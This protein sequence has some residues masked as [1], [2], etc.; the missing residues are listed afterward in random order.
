[1]Q[2]QALYSIVRFRQL[3][4]S[5]RSHGMTYH[6]QFTPIDL[7]LDTKVQNFQDKACRQNLRDQLTKFIFTHLYDVF[8]KQALHLVLQVIIKQLA[9]NTLPATQLKLD[10]RIIARNL[11]VLEFHMAR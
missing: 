5:G 9:I 6:Y 7:R 4:D 3:S 1:M 8:P 2:D 11:A 10:I